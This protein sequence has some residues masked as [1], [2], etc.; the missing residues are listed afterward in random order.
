MCVEDPFANPIGSVHLCM[1]LNLIAVPNGGIT[2][3]YLLIEEVTDVKL[4]FA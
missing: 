3:L 2:I 4:Y 1:Y